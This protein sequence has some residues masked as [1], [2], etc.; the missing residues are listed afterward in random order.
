MKC[1]GG[2]GPVLL[3]T[4]LLQILLLGGLGSLAGIVLGGLVPS[5]ATYFWGERL[6]VHVRTGIYVGPMLRAGL[7]GICTT[8]A[9]STGP[10]VR[11]IQISPAALFRGYVNGEG[12][13]GGLLA[14]LLPV[15]FFILLILLVFAFA[16]NMKLAAGFVFGT[17]GC[18]VLFRL[19][20]GVL[21]TVARHAPFIVYPSVRLGLGQIVRPGAPTTSLVFALGL[22]LTCLVAVALVNVNLT[23]ALTRDIALQTPSFFFMDVMPRD[24]GRFAAMVEDIAGPGSLDRSPVIRGRIVKIGGTNVSGANVAPEVDWAVRGDRMLTYAAAMPKNTILARGTW[25]PLDYHGPARISLTSDLA[26][27]F[28]VDIGDTLTINV[29]GRNITATIANIRDVDWTT[30]AMQFA[31]IFA[32]GVLDTAP[33]T[34]LAAVRADAKD[35]A[36]I[37]ERVSET[38]PSVA[39][40][41]VK[42]VLDTVGALFANMA[43]VCQ[44]V[45]GIALLSGFLVLGGAF[46]ADQHRRIY[47]AVIYKVCG[48]TRRDILLALITEFAVIGIGTGIISCITG[49]LAAWGVIEGFMHMRFTLDPSLAVITVLAGTGLALFFGLAGTVRA[50]GKKP[51]RYLRNE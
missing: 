5:A 2:T 1:L 29:L 14:R 17:A 6:P 41:R 10:L 27:G 20:A 39:I 45:S 18:F 31:I 51:A 4:Y 47:D 32:P 37:F 44:G 11:A 3:G 40:I 13:G 21:K 15:C 35:E 49:A 43:A 50:L 16:G 33:Q 38:F 24:V 19:A 7:F 48:A 22:G 9:F 26:R 36:R 46:S 42:E 34:T 30:L 23:R 28:G 25:W 12:K 8:L